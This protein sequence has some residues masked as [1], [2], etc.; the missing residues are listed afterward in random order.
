[1]T[2]FSGC[3]L[4]FFSANIISSNFVFDIS[5]LDL[6]N[7]DITVR[8]KLTQA[9]LTSRAKNILTIGNSNAQQ[10]WNG[11]NTVYCIDNQYRF[12]YGNSVNSVNNK[13][14]DYTI[15]NFDL[16]NGTNIARVQVNIEQEIVMSINRDTKDIRIFIDGEL[17]QNGKLF[18]INNPLYLGN[19]E[20][21]NRFIGGYSLIEIYNSYCNDYTEFTNMVNNASSGGDTEN[22]LENVITLDGSLTYDIPNYGENPS[23]QNGQVLVEYTLPGLTKAPSTVF[24]EGR[25]K[26][27]N[28]HL[29]AYAGVANLY[30]LTEWENKVYLVFTLDMATTGVENTVESITAYLATNPLTFKYEI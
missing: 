22:P 23:G 20:G 25:T 19:H 10:C 2:Y 12:Q 13:V 15:G 18:A 27:D 6:T 14:T 29:S 3:F 16:S 30:T 4:D 17:V 8:I 24:M 7:S 21:T 5:G 28:M 9:S 26:I 1:M 11:S